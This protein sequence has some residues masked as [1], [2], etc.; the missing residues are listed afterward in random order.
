[1]LMTAAFVYFVHLPLA[2]EILDRE[3]QAQ[4]I[5]EQ[6]I[7]VENFLNAHLNLAEYEEEVNSRHFA[8]LS[9]LPEDISEGRF[10]EVINN[11]ATKCGVAVYLIK[12]EK[13][14]AEGE[15]TVLPITLK[16]TADYFSLLDFIDE[17]DNAPLFIG[18]HDM[19]VAE[20]GNYLDCSLEIEIY[21]QKKKP[22]E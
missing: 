7:A 14:R 5:A 10:I 12:P 2:D 16:C 22:T 20:K 11:A 15:V 6:N 3:Q 17:L 19:F 4:E 18:K 8:A 9:A 13:M 1:M 21:A